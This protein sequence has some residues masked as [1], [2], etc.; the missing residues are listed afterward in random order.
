[1]PGGG[2]VGV[3]EAVKDGGDLVEGGAVD[4]PGDVGDGV[5]GVCGGVQQRSEELG[6]EGLPELGGFVAVFD[7]GGVSEPGGG[8]IWNGVSSGA[9]DR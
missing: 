6:G 5:A 4:P 3:A 7:G 2:G 8:L 9:E 1:L